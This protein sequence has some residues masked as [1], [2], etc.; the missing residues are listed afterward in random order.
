[1]YSYISLEVEC[2][3][4]QKSLMD[5]KKL[6]DEMPSIKLIVSANN[7]KGTIRLS[8]FYG[9]YNYLA[10]IDITTDKEYTFTCPKCKTKLDSDIKCDECSSTFVPLNIKGGGAVRFCTRAGCKKHH[11]GFEDLSNIHSYFHEK[12]DENVIVASYM[13]E[14][15]EEHKELIKSGTFLRIYCPHCKKSNI[16][17]GSAIFRILNEN[18]ETGYLM[19]SPYLNLFT[20]ESTIFIPEAAVVKDIQCPNCKTSLLAKD[21]TCKDCESTAVEVSVSAL[22]KLFDFYFCSKK[23]CHWHSLDEND[24]KLVMLEDNDY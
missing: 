17:K 15:A 11:V 22:T 12:L 20:N 16:E 8:S 2:P 21:M 14:E 6:V 24:L 10:D 7:S 23:G 1:M 18:N 3:I 5:K 9:S 19:L 13:K 4:C